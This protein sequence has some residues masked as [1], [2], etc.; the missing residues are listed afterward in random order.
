MIIEEDTV[1]FST[2]KQAYANNGIIGLSPSGQVMDGSD[3]AF[4][5]T[6]E[7]DFRNGLT[8]SEK[9]ELADYMIESWTRYKAP[10]RTLYFTFGFDHVDHIYKGKKLD[11]RVN[12]VKITSKDPRQVMREHFGLKWA[13][14]YPEDRVEECVFA[15]YPRDGVV[16]VVEGGAS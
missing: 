4:Q 14:D 11:P 1:T 12:T 7:L 2:G 9:V 16:E 10:L 5:L 15:Y 6:G 13:F 3:G 8:E